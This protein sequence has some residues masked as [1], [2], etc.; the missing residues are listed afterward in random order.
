[1]AK[2]ANPMLFPSVSYPFHSMRYSTASH[3]LEAGVDIVTIKNILGDVSLQTNKIYAEMSQETVDRKLKKWNATWFGNV[4]RASYCI[5]ERCP[6]I[7][8]L[9][10]KYYLGI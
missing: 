2:K 10:I 5:K 3:L 8:C 4:A 9:K 6:G 7:P 1:M